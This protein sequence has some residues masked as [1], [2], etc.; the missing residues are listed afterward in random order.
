MGVSQIASAVSDPQQLLNQLGFIPA[1]IGSI[2]IDL[3]VREAPVYEWELTKHPVQKGLPATS[4]RR[5]LPGRLVLD[6]IQADKQYGLKDIASNLFTGQGLA[7]ETWRDKF[8]AFK[9][10]MRDEE[11]LDEQPVSIRTPTT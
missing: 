2:S 6:C 7:P 9:E 1:K 11:I 3:I 8:E 4:M 5:S 10:L